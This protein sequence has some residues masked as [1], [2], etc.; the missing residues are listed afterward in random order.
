[1]GGEI[2]THVGNEAK[3][4]LWESHVKTGKYLHGLPEPISCTFLG[5]KVIMLYGIN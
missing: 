3:H 2:K 1:M 4:G 5:L